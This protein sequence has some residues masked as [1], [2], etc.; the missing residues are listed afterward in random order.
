MTTR[1]RHNKKV[2]AVKAEILIN[3]VH[4]L[5]CI[6]RYNYKGDGAA[7]KRAYYYT[8]TSMLRLFKLTDRC[9]IVSVTKTTGRFAWNI[10][11]S[12]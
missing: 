7:V 10:T 1:K 3:Y 6:T 9:D 2:T 8:F 4:C 12:V 11:L 5:V